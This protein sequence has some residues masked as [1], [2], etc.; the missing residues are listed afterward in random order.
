MREDLKEGFLWLIG[1]K[2]FVLLTGSACFFNF[3]PGMSTA[4]LVI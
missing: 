1:K 4:F 3:F 2:D